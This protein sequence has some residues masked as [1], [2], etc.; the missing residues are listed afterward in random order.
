[1]A[2]LLRS[3][4]SLAEFDEVVASGK[5]IQSN[6][7]RLLHH[8]TVGSCGNA[9]TLTLQAVAFFWTSWSAP[10][11]HMATVLGTLAQQN[12]NINFFKVQQLSRH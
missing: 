2:D 9:H 5:V 4:K 10:C 8:R 11:K 1:M 6:N 12:S 3:V 7:S